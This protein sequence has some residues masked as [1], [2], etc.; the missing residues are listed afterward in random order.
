MGEAKGPDGTAPEPSFAETKAARICSYVCLA[1]VFAHTVVIAFLLVVIRRSY[2]PVLAEM[3][4]SLPGPTV[5]V[6][7]GKLDWLVWLLLVGACG[8][9]VLVKNSLLTLVANAA[10]VLLLVLA[11]AFVTMAVIVVFPPHV[12]P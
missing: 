10:H 4:V 12:H 7:S 1:L 11:N 9:E 8:K 3:S 5:L 2:L 6:A